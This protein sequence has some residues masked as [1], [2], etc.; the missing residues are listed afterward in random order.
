ME[1]DTSNHEFRRGQAYSSWPIA[2]LQGRVHG[3]RS[4]HPQRHGSRRSVGTDRL[5][6]C[7]RCDLRPRR[8]CTRSATVIDQDLPT[9]STGLSHQP[10][11][12]QC[13]RTAGG[14][15]RGH[16]AARVGRGSLF[17]DRGINRNG[18]RPLSTRANRNAVVEIN[19]LGI[20]SLRDHD[21]RKHATSRLDRRAVDR[22]RRLS[23][24][25]Q[26]RFIDG[27]HWFDGLLGGRY[28][29]DR[30]W[31]DDVDGVLNFH[32]R[33]S[34]VFACDAGRIGRSSLRTGPRIHAVV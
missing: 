26:S 21:T 16:A 34:R 4:N 7:R 11:V 10:I 22:R 12:S 19:R 2:I 33:P 15:D 30:R 3:K 28:R 9:G 14:L 32:R 25:A 5:S 31:H 23:R 20:S 24:C 6:G 13:L 1:A 27:Q 18:N 17:P 29:F 8:S